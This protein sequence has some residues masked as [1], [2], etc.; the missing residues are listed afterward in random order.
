MEYLIKQCNPSVTA[1]QSIHSDFGGWAL[2]NVEL[3]KCKIKITA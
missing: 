3:K 1:N 2:R